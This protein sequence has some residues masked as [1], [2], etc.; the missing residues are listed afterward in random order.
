LPASVSARQ[1]PTT[2]T[3]DF[4]SEPAVSVEKSG[5]KGAAAIA[6]SNRVATPIPAAMRTAFVLSFMMASLVNVRSAAGKRRLRPPFI[7]RLAALA[8]RHS[9]WL[10]EVI[11]SMIT[12]LGRP[13]IAKARRRAAL[14]DAPPGD[15]T[16][17]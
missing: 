6:G 2:G 12:P 9:T 8:A 17:N 16:Q 11:C 13:S 1:I 3:R 15:N 14:S 7:Q 4:G 10:R 5:L